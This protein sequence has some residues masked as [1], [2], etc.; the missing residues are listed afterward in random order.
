MSLALHLHPVMMSKYSKF[1]VLLFEKHC[2]NDNDHLSI[3][4]A[5]FFLQNR[6]AKNIQSQTMTEKYITI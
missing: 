5:C 2:N 4:I 3:T 6:Q 1:F